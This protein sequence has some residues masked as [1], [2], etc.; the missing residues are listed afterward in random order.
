MVHYT[1]RFMRVSQAL[2]PALLLLSTAGCT[3][4]G[5]DADEAKRGGDALVTASG[6]RLAATDATRALAAAGFSDPYLGVEPT[7]EVREYDLWVD[8]TFVFEPH[9]GR[10]MWGFAFTTDPDEPGTVPGPEIRVTQGDT[11]R[12]TLHDRA[13]MFAGH[14]IHWHG[15][16][17]PW[18]SDGV[19]FVTQDITPKEQDGA[20]TY[21]FVARQAG[22]YWYHCVMEFPA[23][24]DAG[25]F[26]TLIVEPQDPEADL[27]YDR[28]E[29]LVFHE[30]DS[31]A[32]LAAGWALNP[33][34]EPHP[35]H[36]SSNPF[37]AVEGAQRQAR[38]GADIAGSVT[39]DATG[40]Y[41]AS[42]G[43]RDYF[44]MWSPRYRPGYDTFMIDGKSYPDTEPVLIKEGETLRLRML[45]A[46]IL[47]KSIHL[48]GHHMLVTHIDG[49]PLDHPHWEDTLNLAPGERKDVYVQGTN[50]G[51]W[52]LHD[53]SGSSGMG[54]AVANDYAFPGGM[55]TML[56]YE[57]FDPEGALPPPGGDVTAGDLAVYS[58][59][60]MQR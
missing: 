6:A 5:D 35:D 16:D 15:V 45:N 39:G 40:V 42:E 37:D 34:M 3:M 49:Y 31:Q 12:V 23:H 11:V 41:G 21:E 58:P 8:E 33:N 13:G 28:E 60:Y 9:E 57:G 2:L 25:M 27:P 51:L 22:T 47:H 54:P 20:Y 36:V 18:K 29:T 44:P 26:G 46:G 56:V 48:H 55:E 38:L 10:Q 50:P 4:A 14:T 24:I 32:L 30:A 52:S 53:H 7:G 1:R 59:R 43:P 17:V 19:P